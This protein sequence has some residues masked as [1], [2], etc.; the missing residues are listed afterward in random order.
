MQEA[1]KPVANIPL[2]SRLEEDAPSLA[3]STRSAGTTPTTSTANEDSVA[4]AVSKQ[5][6][7]VHIP[8]FRIASNVQEGKQMSK[9]Q[10]KEWVWKNYQD[11]IFKLITVTPIKDEEESEI[12]GAEKEE[13]EDWSHPSSVTTPSVVVPTRIDAA[14]AEEMRKRLDILEKV[15]HAQ[16]QYLRAEGPAAVYTCLI[17]GI[18]ELMHC[19]YGFV[20]EVKR[21]AEKNGA[22]YLQCHGMSLRSSAGWSEDSLRLI[23][24]HTGLRFYNLDSL[25]GTVLKTNQVT[26]TNDAQKDSV[27]GTPPGHPPLRNFLGIPIQN[28]EGELIG[29]IGIANNQKG[30]SE[31]DLEYLKPFTDATSNVIQSYAQAEELRILVNTLEQR[32]EERTQ[33]L[34]KANQYL[35]QANQ[36]VQ[37]ASELRLQ[38]F[39]CMSHE[40]RTVR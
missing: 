13:E 21:D 16:H 34:R 35:E 24:S 2:P 32:V 22:L 5:S 7:S 38:H 39:A 20:G 40:I 30:F 3:R 10:L 1:V 29:M 15:A 9:Q 28:V 19:D 17:D 8:P 36:R 23:R 4:L 18:I 31:A 14:K 12:D 6:L 27:S 25:W 26:L 11:E 37:Q 33:S